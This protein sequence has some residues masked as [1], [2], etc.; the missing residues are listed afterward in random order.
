MPRLLLQESID[1]PSLNLLFRVCA[2]GVGREE[3]KANIAQLV[4]CIRRRGPSMR[5]HKHHILKAQQTVC[6]MRSQEDLR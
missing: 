3:M 4:T 5:W 6:R 2:R 1:S